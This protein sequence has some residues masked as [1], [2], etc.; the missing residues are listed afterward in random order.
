[1]TSTMRRR[2]TGGEFA[3]DL[4]GCVLSVLRGVYNGASGF[5]AQGHERFPPFSLPFFYLFFYGTQLINTGFGL[6]LGW[7]LL[8]FHVIFCPQ[9]Y[10]M[11]VTIGFML[12][13]ESCITDG[14]KAS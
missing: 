3:Y 4:G 7:S 1:M 5:R 10:G 11:E 9:N 2:F 14:I 12:R 13:N 6:H 8:T